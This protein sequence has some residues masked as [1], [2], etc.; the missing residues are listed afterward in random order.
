MKTL[1]FYLVA[2]MMIG[3]IAANAKTLVVYY[4]FTNHV[5]A[6]VS[7]LTTQ[8]E[9]DVVRVEP[10]EKGLDYAANGYA[11]GSAQISAIR[12]NPSDPASYP[13]IDPVNVD[14]DKYDVVIVAAPLWWGNM[15]APMQS[16]LFQYGAR[17][18]GKH[19]GL[20]VSSASSGISGVESDAKR[21]VP[22]GVFMSKSLWIRSSQTGD[23]HN[24][25]AA[26]L[27]DVDYDGLSAGSVGA[28][29]SQ[30]PGRIVMTSDGISTLGKFDKMTVYNIGG[31]KILETED[32]AVSRHFPS[33]VYVVKLTSGGGEQTIKAV[34]R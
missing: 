13:A 28:I 34:V 9:A 10:A 3:A 27:N 14:M 20:I 15:A 6:L 25:I 26:W 21:L 31:Q 18:A 4:S 8:I 11:I 2:I 24:M 22:N 32:S 33:G 12:S 1:R 30:E 29:D 19:I 5:D 7:D 16:F 23:C 17:M